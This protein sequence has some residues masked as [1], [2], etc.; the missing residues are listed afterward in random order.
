[1]PRQLR[2]LEQVVVDNAQSVIEYGLIIAT[3]AMVV[4]LGDT[5]FGYQI[6][7]WFEQL[8]AH[9]TTVGT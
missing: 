5:A 6:E 7:P 1:M 8:T 2:E 4:L 3:T 9:G